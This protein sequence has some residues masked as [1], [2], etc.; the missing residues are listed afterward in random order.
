MSAGR[1]D[2]QTA[3]RPGAGRPKGFDQQVQDIASAAHLRGIVLM[4]GE[5][6]VGSVEAADLC[7]ALRAAHENTRGQEG[8]HGHVVT[9]ANGI[10]ARL[11]AKGAVQVSNF[12][13]TLIRGYA[14]ARK[15][16]SSERSSEGQAAGAAAERS[17]ESLHG[18]NDAL[19]RDRS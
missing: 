10:A 19:S 4:K 17:P 6:V 14:N 11:G 12:A 2:G 7:K 9:L 18:S 5:T 16:R 3:F 13:W 15:V 1:Y 8:R